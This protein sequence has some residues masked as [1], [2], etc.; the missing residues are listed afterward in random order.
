MGD[1]VYVP[2]DFKGDDLEAKRRRS[3][4]HSYR[5]RKERTA[6]HVATDI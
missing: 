3:R 4:P 5:L 2:R 6:W 1:P